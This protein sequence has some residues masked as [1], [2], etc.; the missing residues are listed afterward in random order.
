MRQGD[1]VAG[2]VLAL[3][4]A[5][6]DDRGHRPI[7]V[8]GGGQQFQDVALVRRDRPGQVGQ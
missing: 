6:G 5:E 2:D 7:A 3:I 1:A 4:E 8:E